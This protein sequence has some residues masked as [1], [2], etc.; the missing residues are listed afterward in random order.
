MKPMNYA[1]AKVKPKSWW[2]H[3]VPYAG[4]HKYSSAIR[5]T[6]HLTP[7]RWANFIDSNKRTLSTMSLV[8]HELIHVGH[9]RRDRGWWLKWLFSKK[10]RLRYE[11]EAYT[12]QILYRSE[13]HPQ[14]RDQYTI[15]YAKILSKYRVGLKWK[16]IYR[17]LVFEIGR[18]LKATTETKIRQ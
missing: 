10:S 9:Y 16:E 13:Y 5:E 8:E 17:L 6:I 18:Q 7:K 4:R 11:L 1:N 2:W 15:R 3:F 14:L 12:V